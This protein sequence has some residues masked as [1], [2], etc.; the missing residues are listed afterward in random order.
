M[1]YQRCLIFLW[2]LAMAAFVAALASCASLTVPSD[3]DGAAVF[4]NWKTFGRSN[5]S[6]PFLVSSF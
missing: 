3:Y 4:S 6:M 5:C 2:M 1:S